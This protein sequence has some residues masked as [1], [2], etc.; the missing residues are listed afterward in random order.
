MRPITPGVVR[1]GVTQR[2]EHGYGPAPGPSH[3][4]CLDAD[5]AP[6]CSCRRTQ[7]RKRWSRRRKLSSP[8][9]IRREDRPA[10][11]TEHR[12]RVD[13]SHTPERFRR[14]ADAVPPPPAHGWG[15]GVFLQRAGPSSPPEHSRRQRA[16]GVPANDQR[17]SR[18]WR[19][20]QLVPTCVMTAAV[21]RSAPPGPLLAVGTS[22]RRGSALAPSESAIRANENHGRSR[23]GFSFG[24]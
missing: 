15:R 21:W 10:E 4:P 24:T 12:R 8:R 6:S 5:A 9:D 14:C 23:A 19:R 1:P 2:H 3:R 13:S 16:C 18:S 7:R 11:A 20:A 22:R 17:R